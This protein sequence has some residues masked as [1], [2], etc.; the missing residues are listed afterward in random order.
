MERGEVAILARKEV[1]A[2]STSGAASGRGLFVLH[3]RAGRD[4]RFVACATIPACQQCVG[5]QGQEGVQGQEGAPTTAI[6]S[7][8]PSRGDPSLPD[9][10]SH[11]RKRRVGRGGDCHIPVAYSSP[12][13][14]CTGNSFTS[15]GYNFALAWHNLSRNIWN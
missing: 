5:R 8:P 12:P 13:F 2:A 4:E 14:P 15:L 1:A 6:S 7:P 3:C 9:P 11:R 10:F